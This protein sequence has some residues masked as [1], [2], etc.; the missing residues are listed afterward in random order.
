MANEGIKKS[1]AKF[2]YGKEAG[3]FGDE[4]AGTSKTG[5]FWGNQGAGILLIAQGTGRVLLTFRSG[6]VNEPHTWGIPGGKIDPGEDPAAAARRE[7]TEELGYSGPIQITPAYV[8]EAEDF[9]YHNFL[10]VIPEEFKPAL[11]WESSRAEWF[12]P[13]DLPALRLHFGVRALFDNSGQQIRD[14]AMSVQELRTL[15]RALLKT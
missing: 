15:V 13:D 2:D 14:L 3:E 10:G 11:D 9:K 1:M 7:V 4:H 5:R 8:F 6:M 12:E